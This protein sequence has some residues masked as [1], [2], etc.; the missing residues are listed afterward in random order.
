MPS[1][2][3]DDIYNLIFWQQ[4]NPQSKAAVLNF[5]TEEEALAEMTKMRKQLP[6]QT[7]NGLLVLANGFVEI[8]WVDRVV[9]SYKNETL[10]IGLFNESP[11]VQPHWIAFETEEERSA[12]LEEI[13]AR[14]S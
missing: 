1:Q 9:S 7:Q 8:E 6:N 5:D 13:S 2:T 10:L 4:T 14:L 3:D 12:C 11:Q